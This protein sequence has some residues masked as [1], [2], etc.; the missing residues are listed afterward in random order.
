MISIRIIFIVS[1]LLIA[2][3]CITFFFIPLSLDIFSFS[4]E[5]FFKGEVWR[6]I[7]YPFAHVS[8]THLI[9]NIIALLTTTAIAYQFDLQGKHFIMVFFL[10]GLVIALADA[11][12][13]PV[14]LIAGL[15]MGI[16]ALLG[17]LSIKGSNFIPKFVLV[18]LLGLSA[19]LKYIFSVFNREALKS[20]S[21]HFAGF[22][23]G[24]AVFY[25]LIKL[26]KKKRILQ[27]M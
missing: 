15:S 21:F 17:S 20:S 24:I 18:P 10:S 26:K 22:V 13:F 27:Q 25:L 3:S 5:T 11:F 9:E 4:G 1:V 7:T 14:I 12:L 8:L 16:Y 6:L 19:F 2:V 23:T